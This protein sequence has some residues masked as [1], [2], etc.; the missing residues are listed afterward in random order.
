MTLLPMNNCKMLCLCT[1]N[2]LESYF[3][4]RMHI[5]HNRLSQI[6]GMTKNNVRPKCAPCGDS[7]QKNILRSH[8][9]IPISLYLYEPISKLVARLFGLV[10][11]GMLLNLLFQ[12]KMRAKSFLVQDDMQLAMQVYIF[13][14]PAWHFLYIWC[15]FRYKSNQ[16]Q[17]S[18]SMEWRW[19]PHIFYHNMAKISVKSVTCFFQYIVKFMR[20]AKTERSYGHF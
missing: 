16:R 4:M 10:K 1:S 13:C 3:W 11:G 12:S 5:Q 14:I 19:N 7:F 6:Y 9:F 8:C 15:H 20:L 2:I 17:Y 18:V